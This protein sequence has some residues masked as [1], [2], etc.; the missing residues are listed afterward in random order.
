MI[1]FFFFCFKQHNFI[2]LHSRGQIYNADLTG[3]KW[4][5]KGGWECTSSLCPASKESLRFFSIFKVVCLGFFFK[6]DNIW[7][8]WQLE[9]F[10]LALVFFLYNFWQNSKGEVYHTLFWTTAFKIHMW[11]NGNMRPVR[12]PVTQFTL[13]ALWRQ[14]STWCWKSAGR[15]AGWIPQP[16]SRAGLGCAS[17]PPR[18]E[19]LPPRASSLPVSPTP[20]RPG[21]VRSG[22]E[23]G[24]C[25]LRCSCFPPPPRPSPSQRAHALAF[26]RRDA[27]LLAARLPPTPLWVQPHGPWP[28]SAVF[29]PDFSADG[30]P[31]DWKPSPFPH[32]F[33]FKSELILGPSVPEG[34]K[35]PCT[36]R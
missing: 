4:R 36:P 33:I 7:L 29:I 18:W 1:F 6:A 16:I 22:L 13:P 8:A 10:L 23:A 3:F 35:L 12:V 21:A 31:P 26:P 9:I 15:R 17:L 19:R 20:G 25:A 30:C 5:S 14:L 34:L 28:V 11:M 27:C 32:P 2:A 24:L